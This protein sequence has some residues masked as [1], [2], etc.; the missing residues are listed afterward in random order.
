MLYRQPVKSC[1]TVSQVNMELRTPAASQQLSQ[2]GRKYFAETEV[3][4]TGSGVL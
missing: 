2:T 3:G 1:L 4:G